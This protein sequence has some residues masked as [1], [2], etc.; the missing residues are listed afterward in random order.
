MKR[1]VMLV[2]AFILASHGAWAQKWTEKYIAGLP[3]SAFAAVETDAQG[4]KRRHL[5]H[6]D[7]GGAVDPAHLRAALRLWK[8]VKWGDRFHA[9]AAKRHLEAHSQELKAAKAAAKA[10]AKKPAR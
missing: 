8:R 7:L 1:M 9:E 3:D 4:V 10:S 6:H 2:A 5:P